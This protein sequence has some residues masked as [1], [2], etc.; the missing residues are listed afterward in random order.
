LDLT[1]ILILALVQALAEF[2]PISSSGHLVLASHFFGWDYQGVTFDL[3][4]H[5]GTLIAVVAYYRRDLWAMASESVHIRPHQ[6]LSANQRLAAMLVIGTVPA[7]LAGLALGPHVDEIRSPVLI[8]LNLIFFGLLLGYADRSRGDVREVSTLTWRD[9]ILIGLAQALALMPG[10]SRSG[11]VITAC[12]LLGLTR[13]GAARYA[14][15]LAVPVITL[16]GGKGA[17]DALRGSSAIDLQTFLLAVSAS[18]VASFI[19]ISVFLRVIRQIGMLP[20]VVYRVAVGVLVL[21]LVAF[22]RMSA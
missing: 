3:A 1:H 22:G 11:I 9:A 15:L 12:L 7:A 14:F 17:L 5:F 18:A 8:A 21:T 13:A 2:L 6:P 10:T 20:F 16:A 4:L 19:T